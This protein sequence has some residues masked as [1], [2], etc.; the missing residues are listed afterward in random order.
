MKAFD[1][2]HTQYAILI[3]K[4]FKE[5]REIRIIKVASLRIYTCF[6]FS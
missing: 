6:H 3:Y 5:N 2:K 4:C 1:M